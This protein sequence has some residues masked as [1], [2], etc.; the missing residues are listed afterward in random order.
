M[1][2]GKR[3]GFVAPAFSVEFMTYFT[4]RNR[5]IEEAKEAQTAKAATLRWDQTSCRE[6]VLPGMGR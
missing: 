3:K 6:A 2:E 1:D 5:R 4:E